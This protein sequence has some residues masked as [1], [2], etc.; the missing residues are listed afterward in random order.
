[1]AAQRAHPL[2][3]QQLVNG[4]QANTHLSQLL[5]EVEQGQEVAAP[6]AIRGQI[7]LAG[8]FDAPPGWAV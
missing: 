1:M 4:H 6:R 2:A 3:S 7:M 8:D 5:Q